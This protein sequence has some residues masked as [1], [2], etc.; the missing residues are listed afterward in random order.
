MKM[1]ATGPLP[2]RGALF[3]VLRRSTTLIERAT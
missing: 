1:S 3:D 2:L